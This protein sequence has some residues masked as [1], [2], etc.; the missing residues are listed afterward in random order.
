MSKTTT[1]KSKCNSALKSS[2]ENLFQSNSLKDLKSQKTKIGD[3]ENNLNFLKLTSVKTN[4][5]QLKTQLS[6]EEALVHKGNTYSSEN[7]NL[8]PNVDDELSPA[9]H[10]QRSSIAA[11]YLSKT[12]DGLA[13]T[14]KRNHGLIAKSEKLSKIPGKASPVTTPT[15]A[16][17]HTASHNILDRNGTNTIDKNFGI[18]SPTVAKIPFQI[19]RH[20]VDSIQVKFK[21]INCFFRT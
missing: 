20:R 14:Q 15:K 5:I 8:K 3:K 18:S 1:F 11:S 16:N 4:K 17:Q 13:K 7:N 10:R 12:A 6:V 19:V 21:Y 9:K 2:S